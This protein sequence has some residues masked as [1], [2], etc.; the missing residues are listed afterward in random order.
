MS[1]T[2][3]STIYSGAVSTNNLSIGN[4][5]V[6]LPFS[7]NSTRIA[8]GSNVIIN[9]TSV[10]VSN[11]TNGITINTTAISTN[12][13]IIN[14]VD[15]TAPPSSNTLEYQ[16]FTTTG[17]NTWTKPAGIS[18]NSLV[19]FM[20]WGGGG[21]G[22]T[23]ATNGFGGGG[24]ACVVVNK[25]ASECNATC[26][27]YVG[28]GGTGGLVGQTSVFW[29][30]STVSISSYGGG[31]AN[32]TRGGCGGGWFS[33]GST[34]TGGAPFGGNATVFDSTFGGASPAGAGTGRSIY[35][36][37]CGVGTILNA[38]SA[39]YGGGGGSRASALGV[40]LFG[41]N[42]GNNTTAATAPGGGGAG[43]ANNS[44]GARGEVRVWVQKV[45]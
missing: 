28:S 24:G 10:S 41:G 5:S 45:G 39:T 27:V 43:G 23:D 40:S 2:N 42:G 36:G 16:V 29:T 7:A 38:G 33:A 35:G 25:L 8:V 3:T 11:A 14:G 21:G 37:G 44:T 31:T 4:S 19:T 9:T 13:M 15:Y 26:N 20:I 1:T 12:S 22:N 34:A 32:T 6:T 30:N 18:G 17:W